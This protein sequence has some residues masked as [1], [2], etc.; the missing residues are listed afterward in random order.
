MKVQGSRTRGLGLFEDDEVEEVEVVVKRSN[1]RRAG[2]TCQTIGVGWRERE[3]D[4]AREQVYKRNPR[5]QDPC[6][7]WDWDWDGDGQ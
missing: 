1:R 5:D 7:D 4:E 2:Q 6:F 3:D